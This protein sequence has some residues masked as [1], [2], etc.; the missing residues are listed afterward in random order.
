VGL[1]RP[2]LTERPIP[3][4]TTIPSVSPRASLQPCAAT[5]PRS[6]ARPARCRPS[7][8]NCRRCRPTNLPGLVTYLLR[9]SRPPVRYVSDAMTQA[10]VSGD[11]DRTGGEIRGRHWG[12]LAAAHGEFRWPPMGR[13]SWPRTAAYIF[14]AGQTRL[15][16]A[17]TRGHTAIWRPVRR[18]PVVCSSF[19]ERDRWCRPQLAV[20]AGAVASRGQSRTGEANFCAAGAIASIGG[21]KTASSRL[22]ET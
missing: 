14:R 18:G 10:Q 8:S 17:L 5:G 19:A 22:L 15:G 3:S 21:E 4:P 16:G 9:K 7:P 1:W 11:Q 6:S 13:I 20:N 2:P 12:E